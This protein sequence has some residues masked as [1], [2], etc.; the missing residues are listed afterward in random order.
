MTSAEAAIRTLQDLDPVTSFL[1]P[2]FGG[3]QIG[4]RRICRTV[5]DKADRHLVLRIVEL[6]QT[7]DEPV[8]LAATVIGDHADVDLRPCPWHRRAHRIDANF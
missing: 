6:N 2:Q 1:E 4:E 5:V 7:L 3:L 8:D